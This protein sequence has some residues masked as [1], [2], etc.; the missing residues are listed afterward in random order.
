MVKIGFDVGT[1]TLFLAKLLD[2]GEIELSSLRNM[3]LPLSEEDISYT[4]IENSKLDYIKQEDSFSGEN[5]YYIV[6]E[7]ALHFSLI[8]N[9]EVHR[10]MSN[11]T[12]S[13]NNMDALDVVKLLIHKLVGKVEEGIVVFSVPEASG[14]TQNVDF[15]AQ[16]FTKIFKSLGFTHIK[17]INEALAVGFAQLADKD[18]TGIAVSMGAGMSNAAVIHKSIPSVKISIPLGGDYIDH[19]SAES[20]SIIDSRAR[21]IKESGFDLLNP[22]ENCKNKKELIAREAIV[23]YTTQLIDMFLQEL[24]KKSTEYSDGLNSIDEPLKLVLSGGTS[25]PKGFKEL[26]IQQFELIKDKLPFEVSEIVQTN[27]SLENTA[28]GCLS[29]AMFEAKKLNNN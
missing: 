29:Y 10:P 28:L 6:G 25:I 12:I 7:D 1:A 23:F 24:I 15:H 5:K 2:S 22:R 13:K 17:Y 11:G 8:F 9:K 3:Y 19:K 21:A 16:V 26:F 14:N 18:F 20:I 27:Q 4:D